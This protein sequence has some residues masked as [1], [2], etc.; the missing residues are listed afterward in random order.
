[1][2]DAVTPAPNKRGI[3]A[4]WVRY[5]VSGIIHID[6]FV[7]ITTLDLTLRMY[8]QIYVKMCTTIRVFTW[9]FKDRKRLVIWTAATKSRLW[10]DI[11]VMAI[12]AVAAMSHDVMPIIISPTVLE[13]GHTNLTTTLNHI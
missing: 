5:V 3:L 7:H 4:E 13:L 1:M 9:N 11:P 8:L 12:V 10:L 6:Y 2:V